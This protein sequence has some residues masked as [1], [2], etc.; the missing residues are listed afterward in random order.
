MPSKNELLLRVQH[1]EK[2]LEEV[3]LN[4]GKGAD[5]E[6]SAD[7][8]KFRLIAENSVDVI[9]QMNNN[10]V[11][12]YVSPSVKMMTGYTPEEWIGTRLSEH[13]SQNEFA[14]MSRYASNAFKTPKKFKDVVFTTVM[15]RKDGSDLPVEITGRVLKNNK[16]FPVGLQGST[17]DITDRI[18]IEK[19][20][21]DIEERYNLALTA[22][23]EG[24]WDWS[25]EN[26]EVFYSDQW[27]TQLGYRPDELENKFS[28]WQ[29]LLH[30]MDYAPAHRALKNFLKKPEGQFETKF[31]LRHK[32]GSYRFI[33]NKSAA[34]IN[35]EGKVIRMFGAHSDITDLMK[36]EQALRFSEQKLKTVISEA[37]I[38]L[39]ALDKNGIFTF[40]DGKDLSK[41]GQNPVELIGKS[42]FEVFKKQKQIT[43]SVTQALKDETIR[44]IL[45]INDQYFDATFSPVKN[46]FNEIESVITVAKNI[47]DHIIAGKKLKTSNIEL[48]K[49]RKKAEESDRL[50]SAFLANM[51]HEIRTPMN[52]IIGFSDLLRDSN[53]AEERNEYIDII[54]SN[55]EILLNLLNDIID[56]SKI[57]GGQLAIKPLLFY[58]E[59][60]MKELEQLFR[61]KISKM[62]KPDLKIE[63]VLPRELKNLQ[64]KSDRAR[65]FQVLVNLIDN[66]IK[67]TE[68]G[69]VEIG[70]EILDH[71]LRFYVK[72]SGIGISKRNYK[73]IFD[74]FSQVHDAFDGKYGGT[75]L[76]LAI[77]KK[78]VEL[79]DGELEVKSKLNKGSEF[80]FTIP[81]PKKAY[82]EK[83]IQQ[84]KDHKAD[85]MKCKSVLIVEEMNSNLSLIESILSPVDV[86][87]YSAHSGEDAIE[88]CKNHQEIGLVLMDLK[89]PHLTGLETT[90]RI[91]QINKNIKILAQTSLM[92]GNAKKQS[93]NCG[94]DGYLTKPL[95]PKSLLK[96]IN[97]YLA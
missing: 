29:N 61:A 76:G 35:D 15:K 79:L 63:L 68:K 3:K 69:K 17:R 77:S 72:D 62:N 28:T 88:I 85:D 94:C 34:I 21:K 56:L 74:R 46:S 19:E 36:T 49:A 12:T 51:S 59:Q 66:A 65:I 30:P 16:G 58:P 73:L 14:R 24:I 23:R 9:W 31:R 11:F 55:G 53:S 4:R 39:F 64:I 37:E 75:G 40:I 84:M 10:L 6:L 81:L 2:E 8:N 60:L 52:S 41:L 20:Q 44:N 25:V 43:E 32:D 86:K 95:R 42:I 7:E 71:Q 83:N 22:A 54:N 57:E 93:Y 82:K 45:Q 5:S 18:A 26:D 80:S 48:T 38:I 27:K 90:K 13:A 50:K 89:L 91:K 87:V 67:F 97:E 47:T 92:N 96:A 33:Y 1:L 78:L 70:S